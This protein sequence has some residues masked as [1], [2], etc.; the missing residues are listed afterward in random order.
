MLAFLAALV[1]AFAVYHRSLPAPLG[2]DARFLTYHNALVRNPQGWTKVW[3]RDFFQGAETHGV[4]YLSGYYRPVTNVQLWLEYRWAG[5]HDALYRASQLVLHAL[6]AVLVLLVCLR[7]GAGRLGAGAAALLFLVHPINAFAATEPAARGDLLFAAFYLLGLLAFDGALEASGRRRGSLIVLTTLCYALSVLSK[8]MGITFPAALVL[9]VLY[10]RKPWRDLRWTVPAWTTFAA[11]LT[12]RFAVLQL[13]PPTIGYGATHSRFV[14]LLGAA[15]GVVIQLS[16]LV[17][18]L[19]A[20]YPE[21]NPNLADFVDRPLADPLTYLGVVVVAGIVLLAFT[22]R[23][24][25]R[26]AF[27]SGFFIVT[28]SPLFRVENIAGT[29]GPNILLTQE[30]WIYLPGVAVCALA[31][32]G[33]AWLVRRAARVQRPQRAALALGGGVALIVLLLGR[34]AALHAG[35]ADNPFAL[36]RQLYLFPDTR[37]GRMQ[38]VNKLILYAQWVSAPMG[39]FDDAE[40]RA[41]RAVE[42]APDSPIP[43]TALANILAQR[44]NWQGIVQA[45]EPWRAPTVERLRALQ[46]TNYRVGDDFNRTNPIIAYLLARAQMHTSDPARGLALLCDAVRRG[47]DGAAVAPALREAYTLAGAQL[48]AGPAW[49]A[50]F[51]AVSCRRWPESLPPDAKNSTKTPGP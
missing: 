38:Q 8:E 41:R 37:L 29:L 50:P 49:Q 1:V 12:W 17:L 44:G 19:G 36:L 2:S 42:L 6:T 7:F 47:M 21:L 45:L 10:R 14:L 27:W 46:K 18:P 31:G 48:P 4:P 15:K 3:T 25:P 22:W 9:I 39:K 23:R 40:Q 51:D 26:I 43:A 34:A 13:A 20:T 24:Y 28:Y 16:R 30:R 33:I 35:R 32:M 5:A 11:Y